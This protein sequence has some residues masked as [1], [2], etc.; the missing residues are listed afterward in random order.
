VK[1]L[2]SGVSD[3]QD[4]LLDEAISISSKLTR[5]QIEFLGFIFYVKNITCNYTTNSLFGNCLEIIDPA[6]M[7]LKENHDS[8][9]LKNSF[10]K[11]SDVYEAYMKIYTS[12]LELLFE[13]IKLVSEINLNYLSL[14]NCIGNLM[15]GSQGIEYIVSKRTGSKEEDFSKKFKFLQMKLKKYGTEN[16]SN[17]NLTE[18]GNLIA[19]AY[20]NGKGMNIPIMN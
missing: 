6:N 1:K 3:E 19:V 4:F 8:F 13:D 11:K 12:D 20:L 15:F 7:N 9:I 5:Q 2:E 10:V 18:I 14:K 16:S 17:I